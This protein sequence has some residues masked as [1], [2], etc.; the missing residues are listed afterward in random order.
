MRLVTPREWIAR[1]D[2]QAERNAGKKGEGAPKVVDTVTIGTRVVR[3]PDWDWHDQD[4]GSGTVG[5]I[6]GCALI[7][8]RVRWPNG[9]EN[10]YRVNYN[11]KFDL[12][13][14][15]V[16]GESSMDKQGAMKRLDAIECEAKELRKIIEKPEGIE[17]DDSKFY[18]GLAAD[19][20]PC[21][22]A[23]VRTRLFA[24]F[25]FKGAYPTEQRHGRSRDTAQ[26][27]IDQFLEEK[28]A[29]VHPFSD[30][31]QGLEFFL[32]HYKG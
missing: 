10:G 16:K 6:I 17:Y 3:G 32:E 20:N 19:G 8:A 2:A 29:T 22:L 11:G 4:G 31:R 12:C 25:M 27:M 24:F 28:G 21:I 26:E 14:A 5:E 30:V 23:G 15:N 9:H 7:G 18:V 13:Y 1:M